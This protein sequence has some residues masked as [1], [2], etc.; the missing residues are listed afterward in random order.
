M[1]SYRTSN[2]YYLAVRYT[3]SKRS[4]CTN[5]PVQSTQDDLIKREFKGGVGRGVW[6]PGMAELN[7]EPMM[8][9]M[10]PKFSEY[11]D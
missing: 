7:E 1:C 5:L 4:S 10:H 8:N 11:N 6:V 3:D 2:N 9:K